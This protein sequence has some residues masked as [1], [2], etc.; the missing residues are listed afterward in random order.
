MKT[1]MKQRLIWMLIA[2]LTLSGTLVGLTSCSEND[3]NPVLNP[4]TDKIVG[5]WFTEYDK[6]G[7]V[8]GEEEGDDPIPYEKMMQFYIFEDDGTGYWTV[9]AVGDYNWPVQQ[10]GSLIGMEHAW[11]Y[12][13]YQV[14]NDGTVTITRPNALDTEPHIEWTLRFDGDKLVGNDNDITFTL[15]PATETQELMIT[16]WDNQNHGGALSS[17]YN[18]NASRVKWGAQGSIVE[19]LT[20]DNW[21]D[22]DDIFIYVQNGGDKDIYDAE[23]GAELHGYEHHK[24]PWAASATLSPNLPE[25]IWKEVWN[26]G[27]MEGNPWK[28]AMMHIGENSTKNGNFLAFYNQYTG[29][30]RFFFYIHESI[31]SNGSTHWWGVQMNDR[32]ASRSVFR[33]GVPLDRSITNAA[34]RAA[35]NQPD[36][37][38]QLISPWVSNNFN[39]ASV[40]LQAGWWAFDVDLSVYRGNESTINTLGDRDNALSLNLY[41]KQNMQVE[42][43]SL[44]EGTMDGNLN[45]EATYANSENGKTSE[46]GDFIKKAEDY[47]GKVMEIGS[48]IKDVIEATME[49][50]PIA[51]L[52]GL[53]SLGK[54]G[55]TMAGIIEE[56]ST[57]PDKLTGMKG[58]INMTMKGKMD[59]KGLLS[60]ASGINGFAGMVLKRDNFLYNN[61]PT[62]GEGIWNLEEAPVVYCTNAYIYWRYYYAPSPEDNDEVLEV[63]STDGKSP[64][65]GQYKS[66][67]QM[68][69]PND[70]LRFISKEPYAGYVC[71]FD[72]A[73]IKL[74]LN[75]NVFT[76]QEIANAKVYAVCGVRSGADFG[77]NE[78]YRTAQ[79]LQ[80]S[81]FDHSVAHPYDNRPLSEAPFDA[82]SSSADKLGL[83]IG[84]KFKVNEVN[85]A[86]RGVFGRGDDEYLIEPQALRG[87]TSKHMM[88]AYEVNVTVVVEHNGKPIVYSRTYLPEF[89]TMDASTAA[90]LTSAQL[91]EKK[92]ANYVADVYKQQTNH[93]IDISKWI[94]RTPTPVQGTALGRSKEFLVVYGYYYDKPT[95]AFP[96]L[97]DGDIT[98]KWCSEKETKNYGWSIIPPY[99]FTYNTAVTPG[100]DRKVWVIEFKTNFPITPTGFDLT[101]A[102]DAAVFPGRNPVH[103]AIFARDSGYNWLRIDNHNLTLNLPAQNMF[104]KSYKLTEGENAK[105]KQ[106]FRIEIFH[107]IDDADDGYMQ[108]GEFKFT[109]DD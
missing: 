39:G 37:M 36:V 30:L 97:I 108:L 41:A 51:Q 3:D 89:K 17:S 96:Y 45:L 107:T 7:T 15:S 63:R 31:T 103:M 44:F 66:V 68:D 6:L 11:G 16:Q 29:I 59:T 91:M 54:K 28:L 9:F 104:T 94:Q 71:F 47:G 92:P 79:K 101:T 102:N 99:I 46:L 20:V 67:F 72:P 106:Y 43:Q 8:P 70:P 98:T 18:I 65:G 86:Q 32:L 1:T 35:I 19:P 105:D 75:P 84:K 88:P 60:T 53:Y 95:E 81:L 69:T 26:N 56:E 21:Q 100:D 85:G 73:S 57:E 4:F 82:L 42:L 52:K 83:E 77:S 78:G 90:K 55:A 13:K 74:K 49:G 38:G 25:R 87:G 40:P 61:C 24:L 64:F 76:P 50:N 5:K 109:Y 27:E 80:G 93:I 62:F 2:I 34:A 33:Y 12:F 10:Y 23:S 14:T 58:T 22:H 48:G